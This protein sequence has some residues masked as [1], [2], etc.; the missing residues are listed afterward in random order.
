MNRRQFQILSAAGFAASAASLARAQQG[1]PFPQRPLRIII[2]S[3]P[4][5]GTDF[6]GRLIAAKLGELNGWQVV[7]ENRPGA[8]GALSLAAIAHANPSGHE[9]AMGQTD[10]V[11]LLPLLMQVQYDPLK[12]LTPVAL[13]ATTPVAIFVPAGSPYRSVAD[14][15]K[16]AQAAPDTIS[17][18]T[19]GTGISPHI[20]MELLQG[21]AGFRLRHVPY[22]GSTQALVDVIGGHLALAAGSIS[23]GTSL[24]EAGKLRALAVSSSQR[25]RA[26]PKVPTLAELGFRNADYVIYYGVFAP[27]GLP[28]PLRDRLNTEINRILALADARSVLVGNGLEPQAMSADDFAALVRSDIETNRRVIQNAGIRIN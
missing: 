23:S 6:I 10:N 27:A 7:P 21:T 22:K 18:G 4:G 9:L 28:L 19:G 26:A 16:A 14:L 15:V 25:V 12:D 24:M 1:A 2:G 8:G 5:G 17:Y 13:V 11:A 3:T 20:G